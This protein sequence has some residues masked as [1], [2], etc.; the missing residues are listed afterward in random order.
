[1][2]T[3][4]AFA[5]KGVKGSL[6]GTALRAFLNKPATQD[7]SVLEGLSMIKLKPEYLW[8]EDENTMKPISEQI[9]LIQ[10][11]MDKLNISQMDRLQIW[12]K[13][14]GGKMGQQMIRY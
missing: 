4:A 10:G 3:I 12:S 1:M 6:A 13:I 11:Q 5:Q 8:E 14:L 7:S 2:A 9:G